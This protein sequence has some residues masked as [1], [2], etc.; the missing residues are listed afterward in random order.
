MRNHEKGLAHTQIFKILK[1]LTDYKNALSTLEGRTAFALGPRTFKKKDLP[2][3]TGL[4]AS[5]RPLWLARQ[6]GTQR[7]HSLMS[8]FDWAAGSCE[9]FASSLHLCLSVNEERGSKK[10]SGGPRV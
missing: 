4:F 8:R 9:K 10:G 5:P 7:A 2:R 1:L 6:K 3:A